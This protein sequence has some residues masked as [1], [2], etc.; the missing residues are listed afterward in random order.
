MSEKNYLRITERMANRAVGTTYPNPPV[1]AIIV[2]NDIILSRGWTQQQGVPHAEIHAINQI[3][4]KEKLK[5][6]IYIVR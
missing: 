2:K 6:P 1:G 5:A 4:I 3:K